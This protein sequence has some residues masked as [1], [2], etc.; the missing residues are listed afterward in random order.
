MLEV[1]LENQGLLVKKATQVK[2]VFLGYLDKKGN[3]VNPALEFQ[4]PLDSQDFLV[5]KVME[6]S[7]EFQEI[8]VL[9]VQRVNQAFMVSLVYRVPQAHPVLQADL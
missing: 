3:Q 4:D 7:L 1:F 2:M 6:D 8:L 5:Q 9:R